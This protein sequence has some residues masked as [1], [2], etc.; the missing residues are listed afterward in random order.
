[1]LWLVTGVQDP[2]T[3]VHRFFWGS[4][5]TMLLLSISGKNICSGKI[6]M[7]SCFL[8]MTI[9]LQAEQE[10]AVDGIQAMAIFHRIQS[11]KPYGVRKS[12]RWMLDCEPT[13]NCEE[14]EGCYV[15]SQV[16]PRSSS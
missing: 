14:N 6:P 12:R 16:P 11:T 5:F 15:D 13:M 1:M 3:G 2:L 10:V 4:D 8:W 7:M 9:M